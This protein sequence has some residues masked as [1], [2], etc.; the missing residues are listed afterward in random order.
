LAYC[1]EKE[2]TMKETCKILVVE[3]EG[4]L[5]ASL[6]EDLDELGYSAE[7]INSGE[8]AL[9]SVEKNPPDLVLMDIMLK[10]QLD[11]IET[12]AQ[13]HSKYDIPVIY[14]TAYSGKSLLERAKLTEPFGYLIKPVGKRELN[15][16]IEMALYKSAAEKERRQ[17]VDKL[18][19]ALAEVK[20]L[21]GLL[22]ICCHCKKIRDADG[23]WQPVEQ[24]IADRSPAS[25]THSI[26]DECAGKYFPD[27]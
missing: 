25:F 27:V 22:P 13:L 17:L 1:N 26:C 14:L 12:S 21:E 20:T 7:P 3:D 23:R 4:L 24:F 18:R 6:V 2:V 16:A 11:G 8:K 5:A 9:L 19:Q 15:C 10:G